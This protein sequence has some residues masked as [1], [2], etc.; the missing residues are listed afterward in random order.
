M[1]SHVAAL[2]ALH[3][4][5]TLPI[6][7]TFFKRTYRSLENLPNGDPMATAGIALYCADPPSHSLFH[8]LT[9]DEIWHFYGG[10]PFRLILLYPD[11]SDRDVIM[12]EAGLKQFVVP[13]EV[14]QAGHTIEGGIYSLFGCTVTPGFTSKCFEGGYIDDLLLKYPA[15]S[16]DIVKYGLAAS[17]PHRMPDGYDG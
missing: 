11:G 12:G 6:E 13:K 15:R 17:A 8:K 14:W 9:S 10:D 2:I 16:G 3:Q 7:G 5:E 1:N 4:F